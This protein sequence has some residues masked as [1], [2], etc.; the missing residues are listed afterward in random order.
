MLYPDFSNLNGLELVPL[1]ILLQCDSD[2]AMYGYP[3][4]S[5]RGAFGRAL[6][7]T[8][9]E[10]FLRLFKPKTPENHPLNE[11]LP[12]DPP[13]PYILCPIPLDNSQR[14]YFIA[15]HITLIGRAALE[16]T[17]VRNAVA[18]MAQD[19]I[20]PKKSKFQIV[21]MVEGSSLSFFFNPGDSL[22]RLTI[23]YLTPMS[24]QV[25]GATGH[26]MLAEVPSLPLLVER[27]WNRAFI[28][29]ALY[30]DKISDA[31]AMVLPAG[32]SERESWYPVEWHVQRA[33]ILRK[34]NNCAGHFLPGWVGH[35][36]YLGNFYHWLPLL[37]FGQ[38]LHAGR[39][40]A[41]GSGKY[42]LT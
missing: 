11:V 18:R 22:Q 8:D 34:S 5:L 32:D 42:M 13:R 4:S 30:T 24:L 37:R 35:C 21:E 6:E 7:A 1:Q 36:T 29:N 2:H 16:M 17:A 20:G 40:T 26:S 33:K 14:Q 23:E 27:L 38:Y 12:E 31:A 9:P 10:V 25:S 19:G 3:A 39:D 28:L 41:F 15:F